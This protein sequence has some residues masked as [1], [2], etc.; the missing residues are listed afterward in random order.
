MKEIYYVNIEYENGYKFTKDYLISVEELKDLG[1]KI[2]KIEIIRRQIF[3][4]SKK[5]RYYAVIL[6]RNL[7]KLKPYNINVKEERERVPIFFSPCRSIEEIWDNYTLYYQRIK[8][9][10]KSVLKYAKKK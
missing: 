8:N 2:K 3:L 7:N 10:N 6:N 9:V 5:T 1:T 4:L